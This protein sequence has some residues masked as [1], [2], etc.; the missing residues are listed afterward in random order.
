MN[1][2][3]MLICVC[4]R[5]TGGC[6]VVESRSSLSVLLE[7]TVMW[8]LAESPICS[9]Q[10]SALQATECCLC[11]CA[12]IGWTCRLQSDADRNLPVLL[13]M[14]QDTGRHPATARLQGCWEGNAGAQRLTTSLEFLSCL[15]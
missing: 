9:R 11:V 10:R 2:F 3:C 13:L 6:C 5:L 12:Y 15:E 7:D 8:W 4:C 14:S 1:E